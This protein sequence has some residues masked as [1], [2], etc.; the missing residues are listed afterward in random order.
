MQNDVLKNEI[1]PWQEKGQWYKIELNSDGAAWTIDVK[2][3]D[4]RLKNAV[5]SSGYYV[6]L[7]DANLD[8][9]K[10]CILDAVFKL[11]AFPTAATIKEGVFRIYWNTS[12]QF[13][14]LQNPTIYTGK[15]TV[16]IFIG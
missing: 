8:A 4:E 9:M 11:Y 15:L 2:N 10:E 3:T 6:Q 1:A 12:H 7:N 16:W 13:I 14:T 5:I